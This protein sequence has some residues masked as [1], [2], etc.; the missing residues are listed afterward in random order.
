MGGEKGDD[1]V[2]RDLFITTNEEIWS[3]PRAFQAL[4][5]RLCSARKRGV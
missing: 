5:R 2:L 3:R 1:N 4:E